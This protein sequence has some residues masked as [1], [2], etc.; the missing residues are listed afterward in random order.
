L[1]GFVQ[2]KRGK[3]KLKALAAITLG[4]TLFV[5]PAM[6]QMATAPPPPPYN[7]GEYN[8]NGDPNWDHAHPAD[9]HRDGDWDEHHQWRSR[10]WWVK[11]HPKWAHKHHPHWFS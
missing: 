11:N 2:I 3:L 6:A 10:E 5:A 4:A 7:H 1:N 9:V 8:H